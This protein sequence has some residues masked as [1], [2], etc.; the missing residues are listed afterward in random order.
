[1]NSRNKRSPRPSCARDTP[2]RS[3]IAFIAGHGERSLADG[4]GAGLG[5]LASALRASGYEPG[6]IRLLEEEIPPD[7]AALALVGPRRQLLPNEIDKLGRYLDKGGRLFIGLEPGTICGIEDLLRSKGI[8]LD[9]LE[10]YDDGPATRGLGLG[11]RVVV[12]TEYASHPIV[13]AGMGYTVMPGVRTV[14]VSKEALWG[15]DGSVLLRTGPDARLARSDAPGEAPG[16]ES[17]VRPLAVVE[18]WEI[19]GAAESVEGTSAREKPFARLLV[20]GDSDWLSVQFLDL[21]SNRDLALRSFHWLARREYLL[22]IPPI[23]QRGTP[24]R[25]GLGGMR[26]LFYLL[27]VVLPLLLLGVGIWLWS[28]RR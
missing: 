8:I 22:K 26:T 16:G 21:F 24:L 6:E 17:A 18:E 4:S 5:K 20:Y 14:G 27:Q 15:I 11:P 25:I 7:I 9:S 19:P 1:M 12:V 13:A 23:D 2:R 28:R 10:V 3:R